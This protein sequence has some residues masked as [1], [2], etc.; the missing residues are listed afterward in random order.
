MLCVD[1]GC[2]QQPGKPECEVSGKFIVVTW[3]E[4]S[5][6]AGDPPVTRYLVQAKELVSG[7]SFL[8]L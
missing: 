6:G 7:M 1:P 5:V 2:P 3:K 8:L 4:A